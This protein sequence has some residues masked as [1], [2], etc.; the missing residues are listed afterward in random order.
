MS[1]EKRDYGLLASFESKERFLEA[2]KQ[3]V[4][5]G[6]SAV[7]AFTPEPVEEIDDVLPVREIKIPLAAAAGAV[8][9]IAA[10]YFMQ[11]YASALGYPLDI[12]GR[13][14][15]SV[16]TFMQVTFEVGVLFSSL[17]CFFGFL[18]LEHLPRLNH[19]LFNTREFLRASHDKF[20]VFV[21]ANDSHFDDQETPALLKKLRA[22]DITEVPLQ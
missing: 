13:P 8:I 1:D 3:V 20:F 11:Y 12:G 22:D 17:A 19:P 7:D 21:S 9:G 4:N 10:G 5:A 6:Y 15:N 14:F 16:P 2:L 18:I